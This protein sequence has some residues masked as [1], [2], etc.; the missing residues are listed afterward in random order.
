[1]QEKEALSFEDVSLF[2]IGA[3]VFLGKLDYLAT[4]VI[5][6]IFIIILIN[7]YCYRHEGDHAARPHEGGARPDDG[8]AAGAVSQRVNDQKCTLYTVPLKYHKKE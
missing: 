7:N 4:K 2:E 3:C 6:I 5:I 1:M 8:E